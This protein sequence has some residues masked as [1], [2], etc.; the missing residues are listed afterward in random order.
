MVRCMI[1]LEYKP[2]WLLIITTLGAFTYI[3]SPLSLL[4][5]QH[6]IVRF[7]DDLFILF[8]LL[9]VLSHETLR[10]T[11]FKARNRRFCE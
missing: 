8:V 4:S 6:I 3:F 10:Y 1:K 7:I 9:K 2:S 5:K 11:R